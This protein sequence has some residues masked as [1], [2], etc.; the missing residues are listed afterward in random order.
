[1][2]FRGRPTGFVTWELQGRELTIELDDDYITPVKSF[3]T[4]GSLTAVLLGFLENALYGS[5]G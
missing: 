5:M 3:M 2:V 1:M 4:F